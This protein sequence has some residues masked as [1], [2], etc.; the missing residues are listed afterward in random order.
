MRFLNKWFALVVIAV[1]LVALAGCV[2]TVT[3]VQV[4]SSGAS[5]DE[6]VRNSG[7]LG[8]ATNNGVAFGKISIHARDRYNT[9]IESYGKKI[10]PPIRKDY[11]LIDN[12]TNYYISLDALADFATMNRWFKSGVK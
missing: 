5:F 6:G 8:W 2:G 1:S 4:V 9:L 7:F 10:I 11:G 3:P 12:G